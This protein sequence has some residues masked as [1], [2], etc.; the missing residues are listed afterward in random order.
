MNDDR[1]LRA[2]RHLRARLLGWRAVLDAA[3]IDQIESA[4]TASEQRHTAELRIVVERAMPAWAILRRGLSARERALEVFAELHVWDTAANN[5]VLIYLSLVDHRVEILADRGALALVE[6]SVWSA[7]CDAIGKA[8][9][10][11]GLLPGL[12]EG[13]GILG[14]ALATAF[15]G[16]GRDPNELRDRPLVR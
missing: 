2:L 4:V 3:T 12:L 6:D 10:A 1:Y 14:A 8:A 16:D 9:R 11:G 5:G 15:P 7:A 13:I